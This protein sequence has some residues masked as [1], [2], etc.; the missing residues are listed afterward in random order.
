MTNLVGIERIHIIN[1][2]NRFNDYL[3]LIKEKIDVFCLLVYLPLKLATKVVA[4]ENI[5]KARVGVITTYTCDI[6]SFAEQYFCEYSKLDTESKFYWDTVKSFDHISNYIYFIYENKKI[7]INAMDISIGKKHLSR[8]SIYIVI[9]EL[10]NNEMNIEN[11]NKLKYVTIKDASIE[12]N[13]KIYIEKVKVLKDK[14][15]AL[16]KNFNSVIDFI[17]YIID[18]INEIPLNTKISIKNEIKKLNLY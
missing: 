6:S 13:D 15:L 8:K 1:N 9:E 7:K 12:I 10:I 11:L 4:S 2:I 17:N 14:S 3:L 5:H 18:K 16:W